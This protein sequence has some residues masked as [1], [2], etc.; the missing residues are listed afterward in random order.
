VDD[1]LTRNKFNI[2]Q[3]LSRFKSARQLGYNPPD[4]DLVEP[5]AKI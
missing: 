2:E 5:K 1:F 4:T 3:I